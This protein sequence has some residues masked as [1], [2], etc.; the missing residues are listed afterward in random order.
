MSDI[1]FS[2]LTFRICGNCEKSEFRSNGT[3][4]HCSRS[5]VNAWREANPEKQ[6]LIEAVV[7]RV[8]R[9]KDRIAAAA[10]Y[11]ANPE[12]QKAASAKWEKENLEQCRLNW[13]NYQIQN[14]DAIAAKQAIVRATPEGKAQQK[15]WHAAWS[16]EN[17][18]ARKII[19]QN[20][21]A[22]KLDAGG[23]LSRGLSEKLF[24]LQKGLC[25]CCRKPLGE[26]FH[27][28]HILAVSRG[29]QNIDSNIQLLRQRCNN[30]KGAKDAIVFMQSRGF[31]L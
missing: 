10:S 4:V 8:K 9:E 28:D 25:A 5:A 20:Y 22:K 19:D 2:A 27:L 31:L 6:K 17:P 11:A 14:K 13:R 29:G 18:E 1:D 7:L 12:K 30:Q 15:A 26:N 24:E 16:K 23:T 21:R 3:C